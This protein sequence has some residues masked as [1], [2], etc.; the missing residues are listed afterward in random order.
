MGVTAWQKSFEQ[1]GF[2]NTPRAVL[3]GSSDWPSD[4]SAGDIRYAT[5]SFAISREYVFSVGPSISDPRSGEII[6]ADIGFAQE[7]V[8]AFTSKIGTQTVSTSRRATAKH[9]KTKAW[10]HHHHR[11]RDHHPT[12]TMTIHIDS[13]HGC[14]RLHSLLEFRSLLGLKCLDKKKYQRR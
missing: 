9:K 10:P 1:I 2:K 4:Y 8:K 3:P 14:D 6:D 12:T 5:I 11:H 13:R 7:W